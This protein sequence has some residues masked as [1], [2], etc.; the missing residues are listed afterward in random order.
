MGK[1]LNLAVAGALFAGACS[2]GQSEAEVRAEDIATGQSRCETVAK[3]ESRRERFSVGLFM[4]YVCRL[5]DGAVVVTY[6]LD[7][8]IAGPGARQTSQGCDF[9]V[10]KP[11]NPD[12]ICETGVISLPAGGL[13][14]GAVVVEAEKAAAIAP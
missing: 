3:G 6:E 2:P 9:N 5:V 7:R 1:L 14:V 10:A 13:D 8:D 12:E 4:D 11:K